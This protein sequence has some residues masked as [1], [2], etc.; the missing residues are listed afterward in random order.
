[1]AKKAF[2]IDDEESLREVLCELLQMW[3]FEAI[4]AENGKQAQ[5]LLRKYESEFDLIFIDVNLDD[6]S[7]R[8]LFEEFS[9]KFKRSKFILMSGYQEDHDLLDLPPHGDY[10]YL[11]KPFRMAKLK[12]LVD[13]LTNT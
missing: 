12:S 13:R 5:A 6:I 3:G 9:K 10:V 4:E 8:Q 11:K 2:I 7:G 1:M